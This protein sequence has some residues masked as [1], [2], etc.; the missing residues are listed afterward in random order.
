MNSHRI[1]VV[2]T[3]EK[4]RGGI[5]AVVS[6]HKRCELWSKYNIKWIETHIDRGAIIKIL[7][8]FRALFQFLLYVPFCEIVHIHVAT[9][10][11]LIRKS[12]FYYIA[13]FFHKRIIMHFHS[14]TPDV[15]FDKKCKN[16]YRR[17][18]SG[19]DLVLV[20]S[21]QWKLWVFKSLGLKDNIKVLYNPVVEEINNNIETKKKD[22]ILFAGTM[23]DRKGYADLL[24]SF[25]LISSKHNSW[26]LV[27]AG[28]GDLDKA[29]RIA[30][31]LNISSKVEFVGWVSGKKK[32]I[33]FSEA[34]IFCL[35]SYSEGFPMSVLDAWAYRLPVIC[36]PVGGLPDIV[37][38]EKNA[39]VYPVGD[40]KKLS[41]CLDLLISNPSL[42]ESISYE[43]NKL[44]KTMFSLNAI[45]RELDNIY[46]SLL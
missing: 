24:K 7:Y 46:K 30:K 3:S 18:F 13:K 39:L 16:L 10:S 45:N 17:I 5:S 40:I 23:I 43:S 42:R 35:S 25:S 19:S 36:T 8:F 6:A 4:T 20:L 14:S 9:Y 27:F 34:S 37:I 41:E 22:Y 26:K 32:E 12:V 28:N 33:L 21:E 38:N 1:L 11:S 31:D 44:A 2:A 29:K 15:L